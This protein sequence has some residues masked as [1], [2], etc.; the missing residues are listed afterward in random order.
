MV[1]DSVQTIARLGTNTLQSVFKATLFDS[2]SVLSESK[3][4]AEAQEEADVA[5]EGVNGIALK[6]NGVALA[7]KVFAL[8]AAT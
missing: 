5:G 1:G 7:D 4:L 3:V 8:E 6:T 2:T